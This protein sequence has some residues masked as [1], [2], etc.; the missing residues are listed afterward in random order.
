MAGF[1]FLCASPSLSERSPAK[2]SVLFLED[3]DAAL[4]PPAENVVAALQLS[5][6]LLSPRR[7]LTLLVEEIV[8]AVQPPAEIS[9]LEVPLLA[10]LLFTVDIL[11]EVLN[12]TPVVQT[13]GLEQR[14]LA[15]PLAG[16]PL[17]H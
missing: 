1:F 7:S 6:A 10:A 2:I 13:L 17:G 11:I 5:N 8:K 9:V 12:E 3:L 4:Q 15:R 14:I 16:R